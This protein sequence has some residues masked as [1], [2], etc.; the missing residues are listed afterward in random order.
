[1][2]ELKTKEE[3]LATA[4]TS[5]YDIPP[6]RSQGPKLVKGQKPVTLERTAPVSEPTPLFSASEMGDF[7]SQWQPTRGRAAPGH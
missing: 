4:D 3:R 7:R 1:M 6:E 5:S 2:G